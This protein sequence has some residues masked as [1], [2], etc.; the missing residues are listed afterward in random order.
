M[1]IGAI[2]GF[3]SQPPKMD[4]DAY[5]KMYAAQNNISLEQA[6]TELRAKFGE[7][8]KPDNLFG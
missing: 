1:K 2:G 6:K 7:P 8:K 3:N 5:A 4:P